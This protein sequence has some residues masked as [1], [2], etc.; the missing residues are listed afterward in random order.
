[1][2]IMKDSDFCEKYKVNSVTS[3]YY[4]RIVIILIDALR[5]DFIPSILSNPDFNTSLPF[6]EGLIKNESAISF[7]N[8]VHSPTVTMPR[9]ITFNTGDVS[10]FMDAFTNLDASELKKDSLLHQAQ[11]NNLK[12]VFYGDETWLKLFPDLFIRSEGTHSFFVS[13]YQEVD[14]NVTRHLNL[15][16]SKKDWNIMILHYL[17]VDHIGHAFGPY[18]NLLPSKLKEMDE[19]IELIYNNLKNK[20]K[21]QSMI[22]ICGDHGM[23]NGGNHGGITESELLT[24]L[25]F[26]NTNS[27]VFQTNSKRKKI[28]QVDFAP[29]M[30][31]LLSIPIPINSYGNIIP[32]VL[33]FSGFT[34]QQILDAAYV[35]IWQLLLVHKSVFYAKSDV[36]IERLRNILKNHFESYLNVSESYDFSNDDYKFILKLYMDLLFDMKQDLLANITGYNVFQII[37]ALIAMWVSLLFAIISY[38]IT[39]KENDFCNLYLNF[40]SSNMKKQ[41]FI[42]LSVIG[43]FCLTDV[44]NIIQTYAIFYGVILILYLGIEKSLFNRSSILEELRRTFAYITNDFKFNASSTVEVI[45]TTCRILYSM[46]ALTTYSFLPS[47]CSTRV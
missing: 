23:N 29:T 39:Q 22:V 44:T 7:I 25:I 10:N 11:L 21:M 38:L 45:S 16:F 1:M 41:I 24:P 15:E 31:T 20:S 26:I 27:S 6:T 9:I 42:A 8:K 28:D 40:K 5:A 19:V 33:Q 2:V 35:N 17:G 47:T 34:P 12:S 30:S 46:F 18:S 4:E 37:V 13:D 32:D 36:Y 3:M 14:I 43:I